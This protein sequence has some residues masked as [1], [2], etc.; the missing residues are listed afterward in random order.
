MLD[1]TFYRPKGDIGNPETYSFPVEYQMVEKATM[2]RVVTMG[3]TTLI[4]PFIRA[5]KT[6]QYK[7]VK[8][9]TTSCGFLALFQNE[10]QSELTIPFFSSSL[11]QISM[12]SISKY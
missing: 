4:E 11:I 3:D 8:A 12:V 5:A 6:L 2:Q 10:I 9:I 1:T 7:G